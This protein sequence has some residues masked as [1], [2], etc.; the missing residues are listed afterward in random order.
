MA[1]GLHYK[2]VR[3]RVGGPA[4]FVP[5]SHITTST[6]S[7]KALLGLKNSKPSSRSA[8]SSLFSNIDDTTLAEFFPL[9]LILLI[10]FGF[11]RLLMASME[12]EKP[13]SET[14]SEGG[15]R[16]KL[17]NEKRGGLDLNEAR[18]GKRKKKKGNRTVSFYL[19]KIGFGCFRVQRDEE[20]NLDM[21]VV[22]GSGER[23]KPTHLLIMVNGLVGSAKD[24]KYAAEE[25]LK[26]YLEDIIVHC[27]SFNC[28]K[29]NY[30]T[31]TLDGVDVM[32]GRLAEEILLVIKRHPNVQKISF[33]CH[34][35]GGLIARYAI[36]KL[37]ELKD[38]Q[39]NGE[40]N[41]HGFRDESCEDEFRGKIAGLEPINFITCATPHLGSR[42]H[43]QVPMCC[44]FY[45]LEK[46]AVCT[47]YFFGRTGRHLFL[48]DKDSGNCPLL[49]HMAGDREDLKFL[50]A[51]QSFRRRVTYANV[52]YDNVVGWSTSSIRRRTELPK[53]YQEMENIHI[54]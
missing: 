27:E 22:N 18:N 8:P 45:A 13:T 44:G 46:V 29:R 26:A 42:G 7:T 31:L 43:K 4:P 49:F 19:P 35:L 34:S 37:Y 39:V 20:G 15:N 38:V 12:L 9:L 10:F 54:L 53:V 33:V 6:A 36:A 51:L 14:V 52:R 41:K 5:F 48:I 16:G 40:Y 28:S 21:E 1:M 11:R 23:R 25:F 30:S 2:P 32:G 24:W 47:S 3:L 17:D 50:S